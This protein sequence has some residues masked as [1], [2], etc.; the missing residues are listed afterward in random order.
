M[1]A[2]CEAGGVFNNEVFFTFAEGYRLELGICTSCGALF[3]LDRENPLT[4]GRG[5]PELV[6]N[7]SCPECAHE[8][9]KTVRPYPQT[10]IGGNGQL[11]SFTPP[12]YVAANTENRIL[13][14]WEI[15][16]QAPDSPPSTGMGKRGAT[17]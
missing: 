2:Y 9:N 13:E 5:L 3:V 1:I 6:G 14:I 7:T 11:G 4:G 17:A 10:F 8:L 16:P 12:T 15:I